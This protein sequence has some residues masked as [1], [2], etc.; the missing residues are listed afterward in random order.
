MS[1]I[2]QKIRRYSAD[3]ETTSYSQYLIDNE[4]RVWCWGIQ[5]VEEN[6]TLD[7]VHVGKSINE[8][9]SYCEELGTEQTQVYFHNLKFDG[10]FIISWLAFNG[11]E[12]D[13]ELKGEK[14]YRHLITKEG[15]Y[16]A[17]TVRFNDLFLLTPKGKKRKDKNGNYKTKEVKI[18]FRDSLKKIPLPV[19][20]IAK[21]YGLETTKGDIDYNKYRHEGYNPSYDEWDYLKRDIFIVTQA[22]YKN[23]IE[24]GM[25]KMTSS[26]DALASFKQSLSPDEKNPKKVNDYYRQWFPCLDSNVIKHDFFN[27][28]YDEFIRRSYRGGWTYYNGDKPTIVGDGV[29]YDVNSLYPSVMQDCLLPFDKPIEFEGHYNELDEKTKKRYPL[30]IM[31]IHCQ[32]E[33]KPEHLPCIQLKQNSRWVGTEYLKS[34]EDEMVTLYVTNVDWELI[35]K[36]YDIFNPVY[37]GGVAFRGQVGIFDRYINHWKEVKEQA[38]IDGNKGLRELSKLMLNSL[39]GKFGSNPKN[40]TKQ[41]YLNDD[42]VI[43]FKTVK[44][45]DRDS[46]FTALSSFVT[47]YARRK[48]ITSAQDNY[49]R[50]IYADTDSIHLRG[51]EIP[52]ETDFFNIHDTKFGAWKCEMVFHRG[53]YIRAKTYLESPYENYNTKTGLWVTVENPND[54]NENT[55]KSDSLDIKCAGMPKACKDHVTFEEFEVNKTWEHGKLVP[56]IVKGGVVLYEQS[57]R[58]KE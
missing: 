43:Q 27:G 42:G 49:H 40:I 17:I 30:W 23:I 32:F 37:A 39:Y 34:S 31:K 1:N 3:F 28:T 54:I 51:K 33:I 7:T 16:Y 29:V 21:A 18:E 50:F 26:S 24:G 57:F 58:I 8:F 10:Q 14:T 44:G 41:S 53:K 9:M 48:T 4:T 35:N 6:A 46:E 22:L 38:T 12:Y 19:E 2:I 52:T 55:R 36:Q 5:L 20:R 25:T 47:S 13:E 56:K 11:F 15:Q 45:E